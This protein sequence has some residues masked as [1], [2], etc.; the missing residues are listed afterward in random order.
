M[1]MFIL[2]A[3]CFYVVTS[4]IGFILDRLE[5]LENWDFGEFYTQLIPSIVM[6]PF[7]YIK[8]IYDHWD[9]YIL[10]IK[11]G[12]LHKKF[13]ELRKLDTPTLRDIQNTKCGYPVRSFID[14]ILKERNQLTY[15]EAHRLK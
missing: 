13:E 11:L 12:Y 7:A 1:K 10:M 3:V 9:Y 4:L 2:G 6:I 8:H 15:E 5:I 14:K